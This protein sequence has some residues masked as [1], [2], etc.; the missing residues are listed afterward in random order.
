[1]G[2]QEIS[3]MEEE[4]LFA[5]TPEGAVVGSVLGN[6]RKKGEKKHWKKEIFLEGGASAQQLP[7]HYLIITALLILD[8]QIAH[9]QG[10]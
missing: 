4:R 6:K 1:M 3:I 5:E 7:N 10:K 8:N 9:F 2:I